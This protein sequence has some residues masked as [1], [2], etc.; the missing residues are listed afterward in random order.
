MCPDLERPPPCA[1]PA[2]RGA[3][4]DEFKKRSQDMLEIITGRA[5]EAPPVVHTAP[6]WGPWGVVIHA[7]EGADGERAHYVV[8]VRSEEN[9]RTQAYGR[10]HR[11]G[12]FAQAM[13]H[14]TNQ[15]MDR[16]AMTV[17]LAELVAWCYR[18]AGLSDYP[19]RLAGLVAQVGHVPAVLARVRRPDDEVALVV[20][21]R[22]CGEVVA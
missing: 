21:V 4:E 3:H 20:A 1:P 2:Q 19:A 11:M 6:D 14:A 15:A 9:G 22:R 10:A 13:R 17:Q 8:V 5:L 18:R 12:S 7:E 16:A